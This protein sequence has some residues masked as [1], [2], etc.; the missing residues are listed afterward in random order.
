MISMSYETFLQ[1]RPVVPIGIAS[2]IEDEQVS[3]NGRNR[4]VGNGEV[5]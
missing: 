4:L 1:P 5:K 2:A 3:H